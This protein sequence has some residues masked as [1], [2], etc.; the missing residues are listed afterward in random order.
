MKFS[1]YLKDQIVPIVIVCM[2]YFIILLILLA[3]K[4]VK[5]VII[6]LTVVIFVTYSLLLV[7]NYF[8]KNKFYTDM[9][10]NIKN[11]D[12]AYLVLE[13]IE[14]PDFYEGKILYQALYEIN[15]SMN[16]NVKKIEEHL[17]NYKEYIEMW[18]HEVKLPLATLVLLGNNNKRLQKK[19]I[20]HIKC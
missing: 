1:K 18:I 11:L 7:L 20:Q 5:P 10:L 16:E 9:L 12:K 19:R 2:S 3:F 17:Y 6:S 14:K 15:K 13:T 4:V 8:R